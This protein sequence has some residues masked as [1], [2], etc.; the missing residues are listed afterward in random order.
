MRSFLLPMTRSNLP[1]ARS[2]N[3]SAIA[4]SGE[5][6]AGVAAVAGLDVAGALTVA[7]DG[8]VAAGAVAAAGEGVC[9]GPAAPAAPA[10]SGDA[11][12]CASAAGV[13][14]ALAAPAVS[15]GAVGCACRRRGRC[16][17]RAAVSG[18][19]EQ[20]RERYLRWRRRVHPASAL[21]PEWPLPA[22]Y[23]AHSGTAP[24]PPACQMS[25]SVAL[26]AG[27][28]ACRARQSR[29]DRLPRSP[30]SRAPPA[31]RQ[32]RPRAEGQWRSRQTTDRRGSRAF[33]VLLQSLRKAAATAVLGTMAPNYGI[34]RGFKVAAADSPYVRR[35]ALSCDQR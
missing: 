18:A 35:P 22:R 7:V 34:G 10:V 1:L 23:P 2:R 33:Q 11:V 28:P 17:C 19:A 13:A 21:P 20:A 27:V 24:A 31:R 32:R 5:T 16:A 3:W 8:A 6:A 4:A 14:G 15:G 12:G 25:G 26:A 29:R 9:A 30:R